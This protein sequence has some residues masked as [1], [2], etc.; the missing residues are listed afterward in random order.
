MI[1]RATRNMKLR[2]ILHYV[3]TVLACTA[4]TG[5]AWFYLAAYLAGAQLWMAVFG[6]AAV[7]AGI[8]GYASAQHMQRRLDDLQ[9]GMIQLNKGNLGYRIPQ[10]CSDPFDELF[11]EFNRMAAK[12]EDRVKEMQRIGEQELSYEEAIERAVAEERRR[13]ARDLHDTVSQQLFAM[14][15]HASALPMILE[16]NPEQAGQILEQLIQMSNLSQKHIRGL[17]AQLR[18]LELQG[19]SLQQALELWFPDY[20][21][22]N[23]LQ[24]RLD[25]RLRQ[26]MPDAIEQQVFLIIQEAVAN[27]VKHASANQVAVNVQETDN[28]YRV[29]IEDDGVGFDRET[30]KKH[31]YGLSTMQE[32]ARKMGG[33]FEIASSATAGTRVQVNIPKFSQPTEGK[34]DER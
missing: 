15:M 10:K 4:L 28:Q 23:H 34:T 17:I 29:I 2:A 1:M 14:H 12:L 6:I 13:L 25:I 33:D 27:V 9:L 19:R 21:N 18:P 26:D 3:F 5:A 7:S 32:R 30:S 31:S 8:C 20:C 22:H 11:M 24:G 16:R